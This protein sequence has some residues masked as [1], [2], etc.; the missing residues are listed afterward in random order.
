MTVYRWVYYWDGE[1]QDRLRD[2]GILPD[3]T[4]HNP[5]GYADNIV[6]TAVLEA[7][8]RCH[9]RRSDAAKKAAKTRARRQEKKTHAVAQR[10]IANDKTGPRSH[11]VICGKGLGDPLSIERGIGSECCQA[12]LNII[13]RAKGQAA[14]AAAPH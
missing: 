8:A 7:D 5:H 2:V 14:D 11:R 13:E 9:K 4:L 6:R 3:G 12:V 10:I 1:K